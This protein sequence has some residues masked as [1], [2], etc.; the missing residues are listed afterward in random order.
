[1]NTAKCIAGAICGALAAVFASA[2]RGFKYVQ[3]LC[4]A[5]ADTPSSEMPSGYPYK[6]EDK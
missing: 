2:A 4:A 6:G 3:G 5:K 1:M